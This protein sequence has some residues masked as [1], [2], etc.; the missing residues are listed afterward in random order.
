MPSL[1]LYRFHKKSM[2][3]ATR[4]AWIGGGL[5]LASLRWQG[6]GGGGSTLEEVSK[7]QFPGVGESPQMLLSPDAESSATVEYGSA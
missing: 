2:D 3:N 5:R 7:N 1:H 6:V 4:S